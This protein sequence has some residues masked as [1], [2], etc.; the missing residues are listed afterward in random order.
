VLHGFGI[1][2]RLDRGHLFAEWGV[3]LDRYRVRLSR[4]EGRKLRR[5]VLIGSDGYI[6]LEA[7]RFISDVGASFVMLDK[8][9]KALMVCGPCA[10]SASKLRRAQS[11]ALGN[12]IALK[13]S[14]TIISE[15][16]TGQA[17]LVADMLHDSSTAEVIIRFREKLSHA[18]SLIAVRNAEKEAALAY[19]HAWRNVPIRWA[20]KDERRVPANWKVF[21]SRISPLTHSPRLAA[22]PPNAC[23]NLLH[24]L[25]ESECR[26][27]LTAMSLDPEIGL[28]HVD[29]PNRSS[30]AEDL[31]EIVRTRVDAFILNW[32]QSEPFRKTDWW[33]DRNGN[34]RMVT[35]LAI[36]L[37]ESADTWRKF[38]APAAEYVAQ[39]LWSSISKQTSSRSPFASRL[40]QAHR[41]TVK[42]SAV[43]AVNQPKPEHVC[44]DCGVKIQTDNKRCWNCAKRARR[45]NFNTGRKSA[46]QSESLAKRS[47]TQRQHKQAIQNWRPS[48]LPGWLHARGLRQSNSAR[49]G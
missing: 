15:K 46:Q 38:V 7:L 36:K 11:L 9:G 1:K 32:I 8:R 4:V 13:I 23:M 12:G 3:G 40:T 35:A 34:C 16:L 5:V 14:K 29:V 48:D 31:Q 41:R 25:C 21:G 10:P 44:A 33:E 39:E 27:V 19:W 47:A 17:A 22:N 37:C 20:R 18:D 6:S 26:I 28:L 2:L 30:L 43:P 42:G 49:A 45:K 24:A